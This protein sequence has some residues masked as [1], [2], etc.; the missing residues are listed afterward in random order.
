MNT[1]P[2]SKAS[3]P[4]TADSQY[5]GSRPPRPEPSVE[6]SDQVRAKKKRSANQVKSRPANP[7]AIQAILDSFDT[8]TPPPAIRAHDHSSERASPS[9]DRRLR[10]YSSDESLS[11]APSSARSAG[12]GMEYGAGVSYASDL[13]SGDAAAPPIIRTSRSPS[14]RSEHQAQSPSR[15]PT[16]SNGYLRPASIISRTSSRSSLRREKDSGTTKK[17]SAE[18]WIKQTPGAFDQAAV[19]SERLK[20]SQ[21]SL[22]R[23]T[24]EEALRLDRTDTEDSMGLQDLD[25]LAGGEMIFARPTPAPAPGP[26][27]RLYLSDDATVPEA[28]DDEKGSDYSTIR[29]SGIDAALQPQNVARV[30]DYPESGSMTS[31]R[32]SPQKNPIV[33][34]IPTRTSSLRQART[35]SASEKKRNKKSKK[36]NDAKLETES[37]I[38]RRARSVPESSWADLGEDDET[39]KRI[40]QLREQRKSRIEESEGAFPLEPEAQHAGPKSLFVATSAGANADQHK[41][42]SRIRTS[43]NRNFTDTPVKSHKLL[44]NEGH[45]AQTP[46]LIGASFRTSKT[47]SV[48]PERQ[49][50]LRLQSP[51]RQDDFTTQV[52]RPGTTTPPLTLDYSYAQAVDALQSADFALDKQQSRRASAGSVTLD[53]LDLTKPKARNAS[54]VAEEHRLQPDSARQRADGKLKPLHPDLPLDFERRRSRRK[55]MSDAK[56]TRNQGDELGTPRR[57]S[58]EDAIVRYLFAQRLNHKVKHP[59]TGRVISF[60]EVGDPEGAAVFVCVGMG[61]TRYVTAFYDELATTLHLRLI[62][63][64]RPGVGASEH[65]PPGDRSGPLNW[66]DDILAICQHLDI[67]KFSLLAHSAGAIYALAT[68]LTLPHMIRGKVHLLAPWIPPSQLEAIKYPTTTSPPAGALPRSQRLLRVLPTSFLKAANSSFMTATSASLK[69]A[70]KRQLDAARAKQQREQSMSPSRTPDRPSTGT[71]PGNPRRESMMEM[72]Q[73]MPTINPMKGFPVSTRENGGEERR[74]SLGMSATATPTDPSF[75]F[76]SA[77]LNAAEHAERERQIEYTQRLTERTWELATRDSNP[78]TDLLVCLERH[79]EIG[80]CYTD[81]SREVVITHG[82]E[83]KR[84]PLGNIKWLSEQMNAR[85]LAGIISKLDDRSVPPTRDTFAEDVYSRGGCDVR[86]LEGEGHGLMASAPIVSDVLTEIAGY[87]IGQDKGRFPL[88][89]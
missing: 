52:E 82:S 56:R 59:V 66:P 24:S 11:L 88:K 39:V 10:R 63:V 41:R 61:L 44:G 15:H 5:H 86:V 60:S 42:E 65:Y 54:N 46:G 8:L 73:F 68:A 22:Q 13:D 70:N 14:R 58:I 21:R 17:H 34:S 26:K 47:P 30:A 6:G 64:D 31:K 74:G 62:T 27:G 76:A 23:M 89:V 69:P 32:S 87:W 40:R 25:T 71:R 1:R 48:S 18:S 80:F 4:R 45:N 55:S 84:V 43:T 37:P 19:H 9:S 3:K 57:D 36:P 75:T 12:F 49:R 83:D 67:T 72:D 38:A 29:D 78:A 28:V 50:Q 2:S 79:R 51:S 16:I 81:V 20:M 7:A 85:A 35:S 53:A 77:G 33:D